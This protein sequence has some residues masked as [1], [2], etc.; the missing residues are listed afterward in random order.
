MVLKYTHKDAVLSL[1]RRSTLWCAT[2]NL[3]DM[4]GRSGAPFCLE[5]SVDSRMALPCGLRWKHLDLQAK[6]VASE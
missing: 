4:G 3:G 2:P 5:P 1:K 6:A